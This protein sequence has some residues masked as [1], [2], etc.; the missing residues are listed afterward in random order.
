MRRTIHLLGRPWVEGAPGGYQV[1]SRK[2]WA[3]LAYLLLSER[4]P[5]RSQ[6][7]GLLFSQA[8]DP[9][10]ALR[11]VLSEVR[12]ALGGD[13]AVEGD[14]VVRRLPPD[15]VVDV[16]VIVRSSWEEAVLLP[17]LGS[18]L[19]EG[20]R[21]DGAP[22]FE[23]WLLS[24]QR[25]VAADSEAILHEAAVASMSRGAFRDAIGFGVRLIEMTPLEENHH[26]L[27]IRLYRMAGDDAA[28]RRQFATCTKPLEQE[29]DVLPG[30]AVRAALRESHADPEAS[31]DVGSINAMLEVGRATV[32]AGAIE[33]GADVLRNAVRLA[34][35]AGRPDLR[36]R[37]RLVLAEALIH[38]LGGLDE[39]GM[40]SL[41]A[42]DHIALAHGDRGSVAEAR[43]ELGYVDFLRARYDRAEV[44]LTQALEFADGAA[45]ITAKATTYLG[46]VQSDQGR[47]R[48]ALSSLEE[49]T[50]ISRSAGDLRRTAYALSMLGRV[51][52]LCGDLDAAAR[53][54]DEAVAVSERDHWLSFLPWPQAMRRGR[55]GAGRPGGRSQ[56]AEAV[57]RPGLPA[58]RPLLGGNGRPRPGPGRGRCGRPGAGLRDPG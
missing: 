7:A 37:S 16:D 14:P 54:L 55:A 32:S 38:S 4:P 43:A 17:G 50:R 56:A 45:L 24:V 19:L 9:L 27:L 41:Q 57:L 28:A 34:D 48:A 22:V 33:T 52:L 42:A 8:D 1:R 30:A 3:L 13:I 51:H 11:W 29:L 25:R 12:R 49:A 35:R 53:H 23:S 58:R 36:V 44:W 10:A 46:S 5:S 21:V 2:S 15:A 20:L 39:E 31:T 26:A 6:L 47:Y 40:A 18:E